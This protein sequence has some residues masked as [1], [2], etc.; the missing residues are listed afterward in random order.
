MPS[1]LRIVVVGK[2]AAAVVVGGAREDREHD[3]VRRKA[4]AER[5]SEIAV[6]RRENIFAAL[7]GHGC[8]GLQRFVSL[9]AQ[10]E[11]HLTLP[12]ELEAAIIELSLQ[13]H[14]AKHL[15]QLVVAES[16]TIQALGL[17]VGFCHRLLP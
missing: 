9:A 1:R 10:R 14:I 6:V 15:P 5:E 7:E 8:T 11:R 17:R 16:A 2:L 12:I 3:L 13:E 4:D